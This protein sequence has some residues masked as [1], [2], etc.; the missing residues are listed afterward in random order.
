MEENARSE[1]RWEQGKKKKK[2]CDVMIFG[3]PLEMLYHTF[4]N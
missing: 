2:R 4:T 1:M 3:R